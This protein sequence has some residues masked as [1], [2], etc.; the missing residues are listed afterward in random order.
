[1]GDSRLRAYSG[2]GPVDGGFSSLRASVE[3]GSG[4]LSIGAEEASVLVDLKGAG[5]DVWVSLVEAVDDLGLH[6]ELLGSIVSGGNEIPGV[7]ETRGEDASESVQA[8][9]HVGGKATSHKAETDLDGGETS[10][11]DLSHK[12]VPAG[13]RLWDSKAG[14]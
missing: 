7:D 5:A 2:G 14:A 12:G 3:L 6:A 8:L 11:N 10:G 9:S 4:I 1:M 13:L